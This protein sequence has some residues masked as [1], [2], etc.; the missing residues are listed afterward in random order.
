MAFWGE[1]DRLP[2]GPAMSGGSREG[3]WLGVLLCLGWGHSRTV[4]PHSWGL[5]WFECPARAKA[6][7]DGPSSSVCP[8]VGQKGRG[9]ESCQWSHKKWRQTCQTLVTVIGCVFVSVLFVVFQLLSR[10]QLF[11]TP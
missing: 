11:A 2:T 8:D 10:V 5:A 3:G 7:S 9:L 4:L 6:G 1:Q